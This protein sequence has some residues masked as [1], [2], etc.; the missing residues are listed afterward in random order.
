MTTLYPKIKDRLAQIDRDHSTHQNVFFYMATAPSFFGPIVEKLA[1]TGLMEQ[2][3]DHWRRVVIEKPFGH[4]WNRP[5]P[6]ISNCSS[7]PT[8][9]RSIASI[10]IWVKRP[11]KTSWRSVSPTEFSSPSGTAATSITYRFP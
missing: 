2:N 6:S 4:D 3:N 1:A 9:S 11:S 7:W 8:K 5:K 10:I